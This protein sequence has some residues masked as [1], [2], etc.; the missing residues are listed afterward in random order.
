MKNIGDKPG[1]T[2]DMIENNKIV[3]SSNLWKWN[4]IK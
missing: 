3:G 2:T 4:K 1:G